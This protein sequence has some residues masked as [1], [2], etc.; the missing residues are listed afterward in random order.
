VRPKAP[1]AAP[2]VAFPMRPP[3]RVTSKGAM[4]SQGRI[5][6]KYS[7]RDYESFAKSIRKARETLGA[8]VNEKTINEI[9]W[10]L[11]QMFMAD[12][13]EFEELRFIGACSL[14]V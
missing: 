14:T 11:C 7:K 4:R 1:S 5:H 8:E 10:G 12:N 6:A 13:P 2:G 3:V 9:I